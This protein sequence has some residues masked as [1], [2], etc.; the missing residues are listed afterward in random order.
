MPLAKPK[1]QQELV[2][3]SVAKNAT[4]AQLPQNVFVLRIALRQIRVPRN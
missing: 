1:K 4:K 2:E 3:K